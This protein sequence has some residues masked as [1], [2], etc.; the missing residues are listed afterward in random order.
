MILG[1][2]IDLVETS[3]IARA[4]SSHGGRFERRV[5]GQA[6]VACC[7][8]RAN[9]AECFAARWAAKEAFVKAVGTGLGG[10]VSPRDVEVRGGAGEPPRLFLSGRAAERAREMGV[11]AVHL[12]LTHEG[13]YAA[14]L[15][16]LE[17]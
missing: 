16:V 6:E 5:F 11:R 17:G 10:G 3:R 15:V 4:L 7:N 2:G 9:R 14:A 13:S 1:V 8:G 12:S